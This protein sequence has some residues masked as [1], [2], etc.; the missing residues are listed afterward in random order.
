MILYI[1]AT[2]KLSSQ[3]FKL[4][5]LNCSEYLAPPRMA[6]ILS[7]TISSSA[8]FGISSSS[9]QPEV[10]K[11]KKKRLQKPCQQVVDI[12][13]LHQVSPASLDSY[14]SMLPKNHFVTYES[15]DIFYG[16]LSPCTHIHPSKHLVGVLLF[17]TE[18]SYKG[19]ATT[20]AKVSHSGA[21]RMR[22]TQTLGKSG[23]PKSLILLGILLIT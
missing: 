1:K 13:R 18:W 10:K 5:K 22:S 4:F 11:K 12:L 15:T 9:F 14:D 2:T 3:V 23:N 8:I 16:A 6:V 19:S 21:T 7:F 20:Q 17:V